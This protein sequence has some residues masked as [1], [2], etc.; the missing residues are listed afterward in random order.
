MAHNNTQP[1]DNPIR[2][3]RSEI[4]DDLIIKAFEGNLNVVRDL[5]IAGAN[6]NDQ[7]DTDGATAH[8]AARCNGHVGM[9]HLFNEL[10][11]QASRGDPAAF[12]ATQD[13]ADQR[14]LMSNT[15]AVR[16]IRS[17]SS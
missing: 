12:M 1:K 17:F 4:D 5:L 7:L 15:A 9:I 16:S 2:M 14:V 13:I 11:K 3:A 8:L 10:G 6:V